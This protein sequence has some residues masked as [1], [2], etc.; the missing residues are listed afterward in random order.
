MGY[1]PSWM[2][3]RA[4][5]VTTVLVVVAWAVVQF[6]RKNAPPPRPSER[7]APADIRDVERPDRRIERVQADFDFY[8]L[9]LSWHPA[10]CAD[11][12]GDKP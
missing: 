1:Q 6:D 7:G 3:G 2:R 5:I 4:G 8:L 10:F 9:A 12:N 11:G